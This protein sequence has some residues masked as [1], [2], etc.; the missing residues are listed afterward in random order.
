MAQAECGIVLTKSETEEL[1]RLLTGTTS[2]A[3]DAAINLV[4]AR[5]AFGL[6]GA[7]NKDP[8]SVNATIRTG[9]QPLSTGT[10]NGQD[11]LARIRAANSD[12]DCQ[13]LDADI[14]KVLSQQIR[15]IRQILIWVGDSSVLGFAV[16][17][18]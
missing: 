5:I 1:V 3:Y 10:E 8:N 4:R 17:Q 9:L 15:A 18:Y 12:S 2:L 16:D 13:L 14:S 7:L 6:E 11:L